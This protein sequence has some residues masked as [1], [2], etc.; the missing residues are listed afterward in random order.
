VDLSRDEK[1]KAG[2]E[3]LKGLVEVLSDVA[4][5]SIV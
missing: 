3:F 5:V 4:Y 2:W 1:S